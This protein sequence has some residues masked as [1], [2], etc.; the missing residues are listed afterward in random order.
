MPNLVGSG[1]QAAQDAIQQLTGNQIFV[2]KSHDV[3]GAGR[4]QVLDRN[5]MVCD[6]SVPAG[7]MI[8]A[9]TSIDFGAVK[10]TERC[11]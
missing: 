3:T 10:L 2:T 8:T 4:R 5:W 7:R 9:G 1:L 11:Q 6:Q